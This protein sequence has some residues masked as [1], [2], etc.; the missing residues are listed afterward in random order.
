MYFCLD[1]GKKLC[2]YILCRSLQEPL[3]MVLTKSVPFLGIFV[4][5]AN[6]WSTCGFTHASN[7]LHK[8]LLNKIIRAPMSFFDTTPSGRIV[9]RFASVSIWRAVRH[10][11]Y[12]LKIFLFLTGKEFSCSSGQ[13]CVVPV[14]LSI[15]YVDTGMNSSGPLRR[16]PSSEWNG[17]GN[18]EL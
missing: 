4:L 12:M 15:Q 14:F 18:K 9:N 1:S 6:L 16:S 7:I 10:R 8:Q 11:V 13:H 3:C 17:Q 2:H 5:I